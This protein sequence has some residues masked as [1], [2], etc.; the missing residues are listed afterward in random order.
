MDQVLEQAGLRDQVAMLAVEGKG[1]NEVPL[2]A[3]QQRPDVA[4]EGVG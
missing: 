2:V 3:Q 1:E 4:A